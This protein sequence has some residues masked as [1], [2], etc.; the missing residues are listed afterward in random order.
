M[1]NQQIAQD[2]EVYFTYNLQVYV[3]QNKGIFCSL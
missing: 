2:L 3:Y 1:E